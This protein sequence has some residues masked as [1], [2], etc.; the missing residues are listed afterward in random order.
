MRPALV[1]LAILALALLPQALAGGCNP[2]CGG[3]GAGVEV[4]G[5][6]TGTW[7]I[8]RVNVTT[9]GT[10][11]ASLTWVS[12]PGGA[13]YDMTLWKPGADLDGV[14]AQNEILATSW[15]IRNTPGESFSFPVT[16]NPPTQRYVITVEP[17]MAK[18]ETYKL[19]VTGGK[20]IPT[21]H[22]TTS[23][24]TFGVLCMPGATGS[25]KFRP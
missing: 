14:L 1:I 3:N 24:A 17:I 11:S 9:A 22:P 8:W 2:Q 13:D 6:S 7:D 12:S 15:R 5:Y 18:L 4:L 16:P 25:T 19:D 20:L 21:C 23:Q 10:L